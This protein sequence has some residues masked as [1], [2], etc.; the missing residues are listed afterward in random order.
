MEAGVPVGGIWV[1]TRIAWIVVL[2]LVAPPP[3]VAAPE[4]RL[5]DHDFDWT[6]VEQE[7]ARFG[8]W[9][10]VVND[11]SR[12]FDVEVVL[13]LLDDDDKLIQDDSVTVSVAAGST[14]RA[15]HEASMPFDRAADV[16]SFR[17]R[18]EPSPPDP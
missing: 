3:G 17:F 8:W 9:A 13:E 10:D 2:L 15:T 1:S 5:G 4:L 16:A 11:T 6:S 12:A 18:L 14:V 7:R